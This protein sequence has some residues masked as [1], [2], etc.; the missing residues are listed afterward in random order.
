MCAHCAYDVSS[1]RVVRVRHWPARGYKP[2]TVESWVLGFKSVRQQI[3]NHPSATTRVNVRHGCCHYFEV[4]LVHFILPCVVR[5]GACENPLAIVSQFSSLLHA[6]NVRA[7][8]QGIE[9]CETG[10]FRIT[11]SQA[12]EEKR[13]RHQFNS[14]F[15]IRT[16]QSQPYHAMCFP[17]LHFQ[18]V[19]MLFLVTTL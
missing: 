13:L 12:T 7:T 5:G 10:L 15:L 8:W 11:P 2:I 14:R 3:G 18:A 1:H 9:P 19:A 6:G 16:T 17:S 4:F